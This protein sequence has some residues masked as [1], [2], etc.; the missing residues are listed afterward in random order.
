MFFS[1]YRDGFTDW[2]RKA[3]L[4]QSFCWTDLLPELQSSRFL[5]VFLSIHKLNRLTRV[6]FSSLMTSKPFA[7]GFWIELNLEM[8]VFEERG[9]VEY[10]EKTLL[11]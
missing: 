7:L 6:V 5:Y 10:L 3:V 9:K 8:L 11:Q 4:K 2:N 1:P